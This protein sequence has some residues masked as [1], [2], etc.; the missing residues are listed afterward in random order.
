[1]LK[2]SLTDF[3]MKETVSSA[4]QSRLPWADRKEKEHESDSEKQPDCCNGSGLPGFHESLN[5]SLNAC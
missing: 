4:P 3:V 5:N 2:P 1:M